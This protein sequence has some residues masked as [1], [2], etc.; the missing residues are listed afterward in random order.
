MKSPKILENAEKF[1]QEYD[2]NYKSNLDFSKIFN[3]LKLYK[4]KLFYIFLFLF[5]FILYLL[6]NYIPDFVIK[7][8]IIYIK[9]NGDNKPQIDYYELLK[10]TFLFSIVL[11]CI[12]LYFTNTNNKLH[13]LIYN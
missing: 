2:K 5:I 4:N 8:Q 7:K 12:F 9:T 6:H 13:K 10:Y 1:E 11:F 3:N